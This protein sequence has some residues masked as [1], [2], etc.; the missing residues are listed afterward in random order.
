MNFYREFLLI[1]LEMCFAIFIAIFGYV[2]W[3]NFDQTEYEE[4]KYY[5]NIKEF[6][7][8]MED[9]DSYIT[10]IDDEEKSKPTKLYLHNI[11]D[12]DD[13]IKLSFKINKEDTYLKTNT[14]IKINNNYYDISKSECLEDETYCYFIIESIDFKGYETKEFDVKILLKNNSTNEQINYE[15]ITTI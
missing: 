7:L 15:F 11:S 13:N 8:Y 12:K 9:N 10:L 5:E 1:T 3:D 4:A 14:I 2:I 6:Q